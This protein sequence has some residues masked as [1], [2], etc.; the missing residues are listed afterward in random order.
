MIYEKVKQLADE[1]GIS[2]A[3]IERE[4]GLGN[5][6][7]KGWLFSSPSATN[8]KKVADYFGVPMEYFLTDPEETKEERA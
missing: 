7:I 6:T 5:A 4:C 2:I 8:L 3:A 1:R